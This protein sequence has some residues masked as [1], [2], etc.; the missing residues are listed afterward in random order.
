MVKTIPGTA[1]ITMLLIP[2]NLVLDIMVAGRCYLHHLREGQRP[3]KLKNL[4]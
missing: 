4:P 3:A 2:Y 1:K